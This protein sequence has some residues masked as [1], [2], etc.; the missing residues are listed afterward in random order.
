MND[1]RC[2]LLIFIPIIL[3]IIGTVVGFGERG[4]EPSG[5]IKC[6]VFDCGPGSSV[7]IATEVRAGR[8]GIESWWGRDFPPVQ[9]GPGAHPP[10]CKMGTRSFPEVKCGRGVLLII[11]PLLVRMAFSNF[12][13][14]IKNF[15]FIIPNSGLLDFYLHV[16]H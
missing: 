8:S 15:F 10:F 16:N 14:Q 4:N 13:Q 6:G 11:H 7:G 2:H 3:H 1:R 9:T 5:F 12:T